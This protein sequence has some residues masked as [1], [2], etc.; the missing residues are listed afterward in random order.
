MQEKNFFGVSNWNLNSRPCG[1]TYGCPTEKGMCSFP[2]AHVQL[3]SRQQLLMMGQS[4]KV[5]LDLE[6]PESPANRELGL[7]IPQCHIISLLL[8][9]TTGMFMVCVDFKAKNGETLAN[10]CRSAMLHYK[11]GL[12]DFLY[13][14]I[15]IPFFILGSSE[16]K[17]LVHVELFSDYEEFEVS[18]PVNVFP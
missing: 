4:Y 5:Y 16:E 10:S 15:F 14:V 11:S 6:M 1:A 12:L 18:L 17:Q 7:L 2:A 9:K 8:R 13:K 3:T